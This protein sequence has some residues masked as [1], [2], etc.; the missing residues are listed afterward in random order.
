MDPIN[1]SKF[2]SMRE[3]RIFTEKLFKQLVDAKDKIAELTE[4]VQHSEE[5]LRNSDVPD[6]KKMPIEEAIIMREIAYVDVASQDGG[7]NTEE[8]KQFKMLVDSL[9]ALRRGDGPSKKKKDSKLKGKSPA[10]LLSIVNDDGK[11]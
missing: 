6:I 7:L 5:L 10:E 9:V 11:A 4:K 2:S 3:L 8:T 1:F